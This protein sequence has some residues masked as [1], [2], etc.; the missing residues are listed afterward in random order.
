M[1]CWLIENSPCILALWLPSLCAL[2]RLVR[3]RRSESFSHTCPVRKKYVS[4]K[5][6]IWCSDTTWYFF[7]WNGVPSHSPKFC[8]AMIFCSTTRPLI[9]VSIWTI[10]NQ[11]RFYYL[12]FSVSVSLWLLTVLLRDKFEHRFC[13]P[14][15][16]MACWSHST[17]LAA[18]GIELKLSVVRNL[19]TWN[20]SRRLTLFLV[21]ET[22]SFEFRHVR[23]HHII[24]QLLKARLFLRS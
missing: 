7:T 24:H 13:S 14:S 3:L 2:P 20:A 21:P 8:M 19:Q 6:S 4:W 9:P 23:S 11:I 16:S 5:T 10:K 15:H 22:D 18:E 12:L 17:D 1:M